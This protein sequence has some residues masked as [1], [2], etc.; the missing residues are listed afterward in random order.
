MTIMARAQC[1]WTGVDGSPWYTGMNFQLEPGQE[2]DALDTLGYFITGVQQYVQSAV[3]WTIEDLV[4]FINVESGQPVGAALG[5][6]STGVGGNA[7][8]MLSRAAQGL[9]RWNTGAYPAGRQIVGHTY[10]PGL[11]EAANGDNGRMLEATRAALESIA[12]ATITTPG[13]AT[14]VVYSRKNRRIFPAQTAQCWREFAVLR[15]RRD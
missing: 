8:Q 5:N 1:V 10:L 4:T 7:G 12:N 2:Q 9:V 13:N 14:P 3:T 11:A 6:G 15:S